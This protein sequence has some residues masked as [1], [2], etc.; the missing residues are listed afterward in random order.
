MSR[1]I[2]RDSETSTDSWSLVEEDRL[3]DDF[4]LN[5]TD[6]E[7][8]TEPIIEEPL[9]SD[10]EEEDT[11]SEKSLDSESEDSEDSEVSDIEEE[12]EEGQEA[13][14][15]VS[16][17]SESE[18][19]EISGSE[20]SEEEADDVAS[21]VSELLEINE[22]EEAREA[23][24]MCK[25]DEN[26]ML[27]ELE[28]NFQHFSMIFIPKCSS[29]F[30]FSSYL[31]FSTLT[32]MKIDLL[33]P[34]DQASQARRSCR[35]LLAFSLFL[36]VF[37]LADI[38]TSWVLTYQN[39]RS[40][41][42]PEHSRLIFESYSPQSYNAEKKSF[43]WKASDAEEEERKWRRNQKTERNN[44]HLLKRFLTP[45]S[46]ETTKPA[47]L[48]RTVDV[49]EFLTNSTYYWKKQSEEE[50]EDNREIL[51]K[52]LEEE[53]E[54]EYREAL[55]DFVDSVQKWKWI[56]S[57]ATANLQN[58]K[59]CRALAPIPPAPFTPRR[60]QKRQLPRHQPCFVH[61]NQSKWTCQKNLPSVIYEIPKK[62]FG[63]I[64]NFTIL[65]RGVAYSKKQRGYGRSG[66][67][68]EQ[69]EVC[70]KKASQSMRN[71][72]SKPTDTC[73][74][75]QLSKFS[76]RRKHIAYKAPLPCKITA[77]KPTMPKKSFKPSTSSDDWLQKR[78]HHRAQLRS[79][80]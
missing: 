37:P 35:L 4:S 69:Y 17:V 46:E 76:P 55:K 5:S 34:E 40:I 57:N 22:E 59:S 14:E 74:S 32:F 39:H 66:G 6:N 70:G 73:H 36:M 52:K 80:A 16:E 79:R 63:K 27:E 7:L 64:P 53:F 62:S 9:T 33:L 23:A 50:L 31:N 47:Q 42:L 8:E 60:I 38:V 51:M 30:E 25:E 77:Y 71:T 75:R 43:V 65:P 68:K 58:S 67:Q 28:A 72:V 19:S 49:M 3:E 61:V 20:D 18:D 15:D 24:L 13:L 44:L 78:S 11:A 2:R 48:T 26:W 45:S 10:E 12:V 29:F 54:E 41:N 21:Q 56:I 1:R